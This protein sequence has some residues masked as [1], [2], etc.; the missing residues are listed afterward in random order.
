MAV[1]EIFFS[2]VL[3]SV[4]QAEVPSKASAAVPESKMREKVMVISL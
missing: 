2:P 4:T 3:G 1:R